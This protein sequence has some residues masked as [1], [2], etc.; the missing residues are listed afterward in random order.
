MLTKSKLR[1]QIESFPEEFSIDELVERLILAEKIDRGNK[2][3]EKREV[4]SESELDNEIE[5]WFK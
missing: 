4:I 1:E 2:Q 5:K 3:S